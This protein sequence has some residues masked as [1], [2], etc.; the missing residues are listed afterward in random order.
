VVNFISSL[1][2][3]RRIMLSTVLTNEAHVIALE[4]CGAIQ[5]SA[6]KKILK[7]LRQ[8]EKRKVPNRPVEDVHVVIEE[9]V[10]R[11]TGSEIGGLMH[12]GKSRNDQ[13]ATAI[14]ITLRNEILEIGQA[15]L[16]F[17][18]SLIELAKKHVNSVFPGYTHLQPAQPISFAHYLLANCFAFLRDSERL[19][20][21]YARV[22][23]SPMGAAA[24]A[25]TSF[26]I[27]RVLVARLLGFDGIVEAS[28]DAVGERDFALEALGVFALI[29]TDL[30]R[31]AADLIFYSSAEVALIAIPDEFASTSS[32]MPQKKN[33]DPLELVRAKSAK[34]AANLTSA[35]TVMHGLTSGYNLDFQEITPILWQSIDELKPSLSILQALIPRLKLDE[36]I[37]SRSYLEFTAAT[38]IANLLVREEHLTFRKAHHIVGS[39]VRRAMES[40]RGLLELQQSDWQMTL[41]HPVNAKTWR[42]ISNSLNLN[43]HIRAYRTKGSPN[44][45]ET[46]R[47][48]TLASRKCRELG[49]TNEHAGIKLKTSMLLLQRMIRTL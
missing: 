39:L 13:V 35:L 8:L 17:E 29:A 40:G 5:R 28:L 48:I 46:R 30:S 9:W 41:G 47:L 16:A 22:N 10:S 24:L 14:R 21:S 11:R 6:A 43:E 7:A 2:A 26:P 34:I 36:A 42:L 20:E 32:I 1:R 27:D 19:V 44:P 25:G 31:I 45:R 15:L 33:P 3:D 12:L 38:E 23:R 49:R 4:R 37:A 18:L